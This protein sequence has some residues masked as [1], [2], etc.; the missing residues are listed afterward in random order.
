MSSKSNTDYSKALNNEEEII[1]VNHNSVGLDLCKLYNEIVETLIKIRQHFPLT[2]RHENE[3]SRD[4]LLSYLALRRYNLEG[5]QMRLAE[6]GLSSLGRLEGHVLSGFEQVLKNF[7]GCSKN[8]T[9]TASIKKVTYKQAQFILAKRA[10]SLLG[11][12][13]EGRST[14]IMITVDSEIAH[15]PQVL[16][17]LLKHGMDIARI[18][19]AYGTRNEWKMIIDA[20]RNAEERLVQRGQ[21]VGRR[22]RIVMDLAGPKIRTGPMA[23]EIRPLRVAVPKDVHGKAI[24]LSE[25]FLDTDAP[26]T[27][28]I[29]LAGVAPSFVVSISKGHNLISGLRIGERLSL[30]DARGRC[31]TMTVLEKISPA[32]IKIGIDRT[33][34]LQEGIKI[35]REKKPNNIHDF[36]KD[37]NKDVVSLPTNTVTKIMSTP[38][39]H[40]NR[41]SI[42]SGSGTNKD[43]G[44]TEDKDDLFMVTGRVRPQ[45]ITLEVK[46]GDIIL[47]YRKETDGHCQP[48]PQTQDTPPHVGGISCTIPQV[49]N[50]LK[51]GHRIFVDDGKIA[52]VVRSSCPEYLVLEIVSPTDMTAKIRPGKG[53][54]FPD[55]D[56][57]L[58]AVSSED[59][60]NLSFIVNYATAVALSFVHSP[61][62]IQDLN[63]ALVKLGHGDFGVIA[64]IET[65]DAVNNLSGILLAGLDLPKFG[66]LIARGDLAVE[67]GFENLALTQED[68]LCLCEAAHI[69]VILATQVLET[70]AKSGKPTRA[71]ITDAA[72][73]YRAECV[74]LNKGKHILEATKTLS[75]LLRG[76]EKH[77]IKKRQIFREFTEQHGIFD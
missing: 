69:P 10:Q 2:I 20:I 17:E 13:R 68:I 63:R 9:D 21:D 64:K 52:A 61:K 58:S 56:L 45:P 26:L 46:S 75:F 7:A 27:E 4:N 36:G 23:L 22:C 47:L 3:T 24:R 8:V 73:G 66:I 71:E 74:M 62:D 15:Q 70:L 53:L 19:C 12:P 54:N 49:L 16:E 25:G 18:N 67:I 60:E 14:R 31:R 65:R 55:S 29:S 51:P 77:H 37:A 42:A 72:M 59:I 57:N 6:Q 33:I 32:R 44:D 43:Q 34:Y 28:K 50:N 30:R 1:P 76:E 39:G 35:Y 40:S 5:L 11:R 41:N 38:D 48:Q